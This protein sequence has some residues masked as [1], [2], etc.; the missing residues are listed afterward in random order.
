MPVMNSGYAPP[1]EGNLQ[2]SRNEAMTVCRS[3]REERLLTKPR[4]LP[5]EG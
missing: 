5:V 2:F 4:K 3:L 1:T